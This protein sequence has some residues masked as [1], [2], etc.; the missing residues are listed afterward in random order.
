MTCLPVYDQVDETYTYLAREL[1][2]LDI[3]YIHLVDHSS[4]GTPEVPASL[5]GAIREEFS[6]ILILSGG[7]TK[8]RAEEDLQKGLADLVAFGRPFVANPDLVER[9]NTE[10]E[11][12]EPDQATFYAG[13]AKGYIDYPTLQEQ[14]A[15]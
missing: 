15:K 14:E 5:V 10:A 1:N 8:E 6:N 7:Y 11:L 2:R 4:M 13:G 12:T 9:F 3:L